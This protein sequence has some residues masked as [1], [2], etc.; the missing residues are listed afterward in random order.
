MVLLSAYPLLNRFWLA[1]LI[2][3]LAALCSATAVPPV[4]RNEI[5][6]LLQDRCYRCHG[7]EKQKGGLRLD[8]KTKAMEGGDSGKVILPGKGAE[9]LLVKLISGLDH[10]KLMPPKGARLTAAQVTKLRDWIDAG[11]PWPE[12]AQIPAETAARDHW[13]FR[14]PKR[15]APPKVHNSR[16]V[17]N[18]VDA[19]VLARLE[20]EGIQ[21]SPEADRSALVRRLYLDLVGLLPSPE[22]ARDF[23]QDKRSNAYERLVDELL[24]STHFGERWGRHWLDL[25]RY[26]DSS[27]YQ[28]D[29]FRPWA[30]VYR[31]W[32]IE[33]FNK[34]M[35]FDQ[36]T[37][38][39]LAGD[40]LPN[41]TAAQKIGLG[42]H[43]NSLMNHEDGVDAKEFICKAKV[44]R[45]STTGNVWLGLTV[46]CAECHT[47]KYDPISQRE[48]Y[49]LYAFFNNTEEQ[50]I[51]AIQPAELERY[52]QRKKAVEEELAALKAAFS[53]AKA[54]SRTN[55][56]LWEKQV[57]LPA[58]R[59][60]VLS[61]TNA[62]S[63][64][65][66]VLRVEKDQSIR[67]AG[68][69]RPFDHYIVEVATN[70]SAITGFRLEILPPEGKAAR[71]AQGS[72]TL[73]EF[74]VKLVE[75]DGRSRQ[76]ILQHAA[77]DFSAKND[78]VSAAIDGNLTKGWSVGPE[79]SR[80]HVAVFE[81][82]EKLN[83]PPGGKLVFRLSQRNGFTTAPGRFR[84]SATTSATPLSP[85][86][87]PDNIV[88]ILNTPPAARKS[89]EQD[90]LA[91]YYREEVDPVTS[92]LEH[93]MQQ[94]SARMPSYREPLAQSFVEGTNN[95]PTFV[96]VRGDFLRP[97]EQVQPGVFGAL[98]PFKPRCQKPD[99][100]DLAK[101]IVDPANPLASRVTVN[102]IWQHLFGR[103]LVESVGD[104][105]TR[106]QKP[107]HPE[108]LDWLATEFPRVGWS[109][110]A[111]IKLMVMS[112]AYRQSSHT[113]QDLQ[114]RDPENVLVARQGRFRLESE[115][116]RDVYLCASG[117][118]NDEVGGPSIRPV[119]PDSFKALGGAGAFTWTDTEGQEKY[120][121]GLYVITQRT[122]PYP[123]TMT[124][125]GPSAAETCPRRECSDTPLQAL[126]LMNNPVFVECAQALGQR[127]QREESSPR[128][129]IERG[130]EL[131][132]GRL[133]ANREL[134]RLEQLYE[135]TLHVARQNPAGAEKAAGTE[136][137][138]TASSE[139]AAM[140]TV[141]QVLLNLDEFL[142]RE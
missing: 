74:S 130:F 32:V 109:Q 8:V 51:T 31:N 2:A 121:R 55:Q 27:G 90:A 70:L 20:A 106:G 58:S 73:A 54:Q 12:E 15:V 63:T 64:E 77:A 123:V 84:I 57:G 108:L 134:S 82:R 47:H 79:S 35:P 52:Q 97:G 139:T 91:K 40:L 113:R 33:A 112:S 133:P 46:G 17:R 34:D 9:S 68:R 94:V 19:F 10:D 3:W 119:T 101:W 41:A 116:I 118:L 124:F 125:D 61:A 50:D 117:K 48:F 92:S 137:D 38:E 107:S 28:V 136:F 18:P 83:L 13:A 76:V 75:A 105:G 131:C 86:L 110:K 66:T 81:V 85:D 24:A 25:A 30:Y 65:G 129:R 103:G 36:F 11:A 127:L 132:L 88:Q 6:P 93:E 140:V 98:H 37:I 44:D 21:P 100:L 23:A 22:Q 71:K 5:Q 135:A 96:H 72:Q 95:R 60:F 26:A 115:I 122:V 53:A 4:Y 111:M 87:L 89:A 102:R 104:F 128:Q 69:I 62:V 56:A 141:A 99:R 126:T 120:K 67:A 43:R 114:D 49:Q 138:R 7:T 59:W 1:G 45:V 42:F 14:P 29:R 16:W 142:T 80:R 78:P 39:Q